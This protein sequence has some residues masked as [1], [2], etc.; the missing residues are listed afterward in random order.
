M[1]NHGENLS[2]TEK[3]ILHQTKQMQKSFKMLQN[4]IIE[5]RRAVTAG[6]VVDR[7][8]NLA[9]ASR[10]PIRALTDELDD[11]KGL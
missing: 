11:W 9:G 1:G 8:A 2:I 5:L 10:E 4:E 3:L 6:N 7:L